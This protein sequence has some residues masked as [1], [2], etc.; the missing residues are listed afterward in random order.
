MVQ[1]NVNPELLNKAGELL[2]LSDEEILAL[3]LGINEKW[4][5]NYQMAMTIKLRGTLRS[6]NKEIITLRRSTNISSWIMGVMTF[7]ILV[8]TGILVY[9]GL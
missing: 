8:L 4:A 5:E 3:S 2:N 6:L 9:K 1:K 7:A